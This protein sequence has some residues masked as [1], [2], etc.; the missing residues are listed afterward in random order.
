[1]HRRELRDSKSRSLGQAD[2]NTEQVRRDRRDIETVDRR[3]R[4]RS[5]WLFNRVNLLAER[6]ARRKKRFVSAYMPVVTSMR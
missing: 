1:M 6:N 3:F 4:I 2:I 5:G